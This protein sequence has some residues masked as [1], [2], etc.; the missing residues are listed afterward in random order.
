MEESVCLWLGEPLLL[1]NRSH[2]CHMSISVF[3]CD[4]G[5]ANTRVWS[6]PERTPSALCQLSN[7]FSNTLLA[8][9]AKSLQLC[10]TLCDP[11]DCSPLGSSVSGILQAR[12]PEWVAISFS[13][14]IAGGFSQQART[15]AQQKGAH[16]PLAPDVD[17]LPATNSQVPTPAVAEQST[18]GHAI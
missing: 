13:K 9:A 6:Q 11:M 4:Q 12:T 18:S 5:S 16:P 8:A 2:H 7:P 15:W 14:Y 10:P 3:V 17:D 1:E